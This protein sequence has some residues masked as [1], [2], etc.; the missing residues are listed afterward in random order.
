MSDT[1]AQTLPVQNALNLIAEIKSPQDQAIL[2]AM[3]EQ[4]GG[5]NANI[6][7]AVGTVHFARFVFLANNTQIGLFT[8]YDGSF[9]DY[10]LD[11]V[12]VA[13]DLFNA[14]LAH[15]ADPPPLPVEQHPQEFLAW[16]HAHDAPSIG[17]PLYSAY[18]TLKVQDILSLAAQQ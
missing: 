11:F 8:E 9:D 4:S 6:L 3:I 2:K 1:T 17:G 15:V 7:T 18:P 13:H 10:V 12:R 16:V 5:A 14:L